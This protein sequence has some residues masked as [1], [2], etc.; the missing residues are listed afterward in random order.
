MS[1]TTET[2]VEAASDELTDGS[3]DWRR[4]R[5]A[6]NREREQR[7]LLASQLDHERDERRQV[8][9]ARA[10]DAELVGDL[11]AQ[12]TFLRA[13]VDIDQPAGRNFAA[14]YDGA[15]SPDEVQ[16]AYAAYLADARA[17]A[18]DFAA[19]LQRSANG[20]SHG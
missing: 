17:A 3:P 1:E 12:V 13:G 4:A 8:E 19:H 15:L 11:T 2:A 18:H 20:D 14:H 16:A 5:E 9:A 10:A 7:Q 6:L